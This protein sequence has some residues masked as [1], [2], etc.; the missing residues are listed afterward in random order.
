[1]SGITLK[2]SDPIDIPI[3]DTGKDTIFIDSTAIP[4]APS[5]KDDVGVV[6][7]LKGSIG[8]TGSQGP[9]GPAGFGLDGEDGEFIISQ[10]GPQGNAGLTG[11]QGP[12]GPVIFVSDGLDGEN[13]FSVSSPSTSSSGGSDVLKTRVVLTDAQIKTL[14]TVPVEVIPAPGTGKFINVIECMVMKESTSGAYG[15][16]ASFSLRFNGITDELIPATSIL[17]ASANKRWQKVPGGSVG[18]T[19]DPINKS[20]VARTTADVTGGNA[21]NYLVVETIYTIVTDGP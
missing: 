15:S 5:Y 10:P 2:E 4:P 19:T 18:N 9:I 6:R 8:T 12:L 11:A 1:M 13:G 7:T 3:P 14:S 17:L 16:N 21:S 20:V